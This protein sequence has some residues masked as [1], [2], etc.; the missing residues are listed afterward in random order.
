MGIVGVINN[1]APLITVFLAWILL[2]ERIGKGE[3]AFLLCILAGCMT[4]VLGANSADSN[5]DTPSES[6]ILYF[7][8]MTCPIF[9][10]GGTIA[11]RKMRKLNSNT[12]SFYINLTCLV[13]NLIII[14]CLPNQRGAWHV[15]NKFGWF[16]W[17]LSVTCGALTIA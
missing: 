13:F 14:E 11:L 15:L 7:A 8:L 5:Y 16:E 2:K 10:G 17:T 3:F 1:L 12:V 9:S 4:M 6:P